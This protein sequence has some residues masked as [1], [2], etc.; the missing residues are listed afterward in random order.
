MSAGCHL[1]ELLDVDRLRRKEHVDCNTKLSG[2][3]DLRPPCQPPLAVLDQAEH[4]HRDS[5]YAAD[6]GEGQPFTVAPAPQFAHRFGFRTHATHGARER[7]LV[8]IVLKRNPRATRRVVKSCV[9]M[10]Q[11]TRQP[12]NEAIGRRVKKLREQAD[13][14]QAALLLKARSWGLTW[15][16]STLAK[17][18]L[19][20]RSLGFDEAPLLAGA[21]EVL[22]A[23]LVPATPMWLSLSPRA[24]IRSEALR[25]LLAGADPNELPLRH[26]DVEWSR[27]T[28]RTI[29]RTLAGWTETAER[30]VPFWP[31]ASAKTMLMARE[32]AAGEAE[33][34]L[35]LKLQLHPE[36]LSILAYRCWGKSLTEE[37]EQRLGDRRAQHKGADP[38]AL[39]G[40]IT[41]D[42]KAEIEA[43]RETFAKKDRGTT[44]P[45]SPAAASVARLRKQILSDVKPL[46]KE[47][48]R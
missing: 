46:P 27:R 47:G 43:A 37:R 12:F 1:R 25:A 35:A 36:V 18:E 7:L 31:A 38:A 26:F 45:K 23:D 13:L 15:T 28:R 29:T 41:R 4:G 17:I 19:G 5:R 16:R 30:I 34:R 42:L 2:H 20:E 10:E 32:A 48:N 33:Q 44:A 3:D 24:A 8:S 40:R 9:N 14:S 22:V 11:G 21:L 39:R 6:F